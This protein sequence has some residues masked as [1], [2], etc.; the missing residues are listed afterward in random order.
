M[1]RLA[2]CAILVGGLTSGSAV[3]SEKQSFKLR[4]LK[5]AY[6]LQG[7]TASGTYVHRG[8]VA[9]DP[10]VIRM[11]SRMYIPGYGKGH[12]EDTGSAVKGRHIDVWMSSCS[13]AMRST[14]MV[15]ITVYK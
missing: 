9:V 6:C 12:A 8:S 11:G 1:K 7:H 10:R 14:R 15:T 13:A 5:T 4:V 2:V 3:A